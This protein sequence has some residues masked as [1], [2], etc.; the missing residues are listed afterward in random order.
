MRPH[1]APVEGQEAGIEVTQAMAADALGWLSRMLLIREFESTAAPLVASGAIPGG[2]HS[3]IG[4]EAVSV[5]VLSVLGPDD[6]A[7]ASHRSHHVAL[8]KGMDPS[9]VMA[10][11][12]GKATGCAGGRGGH[13]HL[14]DFAVGFDGSNG[15]VEAGLGIAR[16]VPRSPTDTG[17][18]GIAR[19][20][21]SATAVP[22]PA[23]CGSS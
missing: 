10:E 18:T 2:M 7:A 23:G 17:R 13:M 1:T 14:A 16:S 5:G 4:Q 6:V 11:L 8:A 20:A 21:F 12:F 3:A 9:V 22:T 19:P 15:I